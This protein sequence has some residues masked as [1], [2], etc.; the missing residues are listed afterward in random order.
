MRWGG[1][2]CAGPKMLPA[3]RARFLQGYEAVA[4]QIA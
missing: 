4:K 1:A 3:D 2:T